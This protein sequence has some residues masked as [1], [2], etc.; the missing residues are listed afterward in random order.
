MSSRVMR[1]LLKLYPRRVRK[2]YGDELLDLHDELRAQGDASRTSLI[3]DT[4]AGALLVRPVRQRAYLAV[5]ALIVIAG[6]ALAGTMISGGGNAS[7]KVAALRPRVRLAVGTAVAVPYGTC[8]VADGSS[9]SLSACD[10]FIA[11]G[12]TEDAVAHTVVPSDLGKAR[13][14]VYPQTRPHVVF[15]AGDQTSTSATPAGR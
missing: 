3:R 13:C 11:Q 12:S 4:V 7:T 15:V 9:C 2:R 8:F 1:L 6:L 5:G 10:E 14:A